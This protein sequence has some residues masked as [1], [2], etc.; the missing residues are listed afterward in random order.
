MA[1]DKNGPYL[2]NSHSTIP[3]TTL[4]VVPKTMTG[5]AT[6]NIFTAV[7]VTTPSAAVNIG[8]SDLQKHLH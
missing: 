5:P 4:A 7:P 8:H 3:Y 1:D 6:E 2:V